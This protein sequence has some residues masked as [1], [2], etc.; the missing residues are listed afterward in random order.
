[1]VTDLWGVIS[2]FTYVWDFLQK[3]IGVWFSFAL[4]N[5]KWACS[6]RSQPS[7]WILTHCEVHRILAPFIHAEATHPRHGGR[8]WVTQVSAGDYRSMA[9]T[10]ANQRWH[11]HP[12]GDSL[13]CHGGARAPSAQ[14]SDFSLETRN[15]GIS[16]KSFVS[17]NF[18]LC[19]GKLFF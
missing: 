10:V 13:C 4:L 11:R 12:K 17:V 6:Y 3:R 14:S 19:V 8:I 16:V 5:F 9:G 18:A 1:M 2:T 7:G 15:P